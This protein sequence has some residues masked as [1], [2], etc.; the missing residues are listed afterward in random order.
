[1]IRTPAL[2][3][4][5]VLLTAPAA[6][7]HHNFAAHYSQDVTV[8]ISGTVQ[9]FRFVNPH[10]RVYLEVPME[11]GQSE[12]WMAEGDA[13]VA[14]RRAG[15][16]EDQLMPGDE[17]SIV[18]NP[19]RDSSQARPNSQRPNTRPF[20]SNALIFQASVETRTVLCAELRPCFGKLF[21]SGFQVLH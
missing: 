5:V 17:V 12:T 7:S 3:A 10:V 14:L 19:A 2:L 13:S 9:E 16:T 11:D 1:M 21:N 15:W 4:A 8:E 6:W 20:V 18:G